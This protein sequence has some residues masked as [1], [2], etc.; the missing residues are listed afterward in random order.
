MRFEEVAVRILLH[1]DE[2]F[3]LS[4]TE[5]QQG[6][7]ENIVAGHFPCAGREGEI[8]TGWS[9]C[10]Q[11]RN[12]EP[13]FAPDIFPASLLNAPRKG[14]LSLQNPPSQNSVEVKGGCL[15][16][17]G[18]SSYKWDYLHEW[19]PKSGVGKGIFPSLG[20]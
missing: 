12:G 6:G 16:R 5:A 1:E 2:D 4:L 8:S 18:I 7:L 10:S 13:G 20:H 3:S 15:D 19:L 17:S 14:W 9:G 11:A